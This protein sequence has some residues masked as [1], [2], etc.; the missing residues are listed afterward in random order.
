MNCSN[1]NDANT[2]KA[3]RSHGRQVGGYEKESRAE[4]IKSTEF[5]TYLGVSRE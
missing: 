4:A 3:M 1:R 5:G 2:L